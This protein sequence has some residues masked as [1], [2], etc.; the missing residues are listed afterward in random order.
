[1]S[2]R[3]DYKEKVRLVS[4]EFVRQTACLNANTE[5][6]YVAAAVREAQNM[7]LNT[8]IGTPLLT[9]LCRKTYEKEEYDD[10]EKTL[11]GYI[12]YFIAYDAAA[13]LVFK[14]YGKVSNAGVTVNKDETYEPAD[15]KYITFLSEKYQNLA[16][17]YAGR[18]TDCLKEMNISAGDKEKG[19]MKP[20]LSSMARCG[21]YLG[22]ARGK[23]I[24]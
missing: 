15:F 16:D 12:E 17:F 19:D 7:S 1:M 24:R 14:M 21:I 8:L 22:G 3:I 23:R 18:I 6:K 20:S 9:E 4:A 5:S 11:L 2:D 10:D 13:R